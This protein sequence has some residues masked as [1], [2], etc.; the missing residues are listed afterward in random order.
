MK[1]IVET[2]LCACFAA[3]CWIPAA[4]AAAATRDPDVYPLEERFV[5]AGGVMIYTKTIGRGKPLV[6]LHGGPGASHEYFLPYLLPLARHH[7]LVFIDERGSGKS[8]KLEDVSGYTV[9]AMVRDIEAVRR[10]LGLGKIDL[11]GHS[12]GG[13]LAQ[14]Y[15]LEHQERLSHLVLASTFHSTRAMNQVF[16]QMKDKMPA[17]LRERIDAMEGNGLF[18]HGKPYEQGRYSNEYMIAAWGEGY[19]PYVYANR[20]D[21]SDDPTQ[22]APA[23]D[24]YREMW[25]SHGEFIIDGNLESV[26]Y[27]DRLPAIRTATLLIVGDRDECDQSLSQDMHRLISGSKLVVLPRS[28]HMTFVDQRRMFLESVESFLR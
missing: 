17:E 9:E 12:F 2:A 8:E 21:P 28:G 3:L 4:H 16:R 15:A 14:A 6:I 11:L 13:V 20:P 27:A 26:E 23:W 24:V 25:G 18:G 5:D 7:E 19:F 1:P 22:D 10:A